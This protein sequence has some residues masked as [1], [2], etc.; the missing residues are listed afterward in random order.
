MVWSPCH[1]TMC[2]YVT[3][4]EVWILRLNRTRYYLG[5]WTDYRDAVYILLGWADVAM[6]W[7]C[8][9]NRVRFPFLPSISRWD[10][11]ILG[12]LLDRLEAA[13]QRAELMLNG[14]H[15]K[16][17]LF[18]SGLLFLLFLPFFSLQVFFF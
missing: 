18:F 1:A 4:V 2:L 10:G 13:Q 3:V 12:G 8:I 15:L 14:V 11:P 6:H 5:N 16:L 7:Q 17:V 9:G